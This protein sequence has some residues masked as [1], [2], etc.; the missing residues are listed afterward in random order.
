MV[1]VRQNLTG[2][3][4]MY[5]KVNN[6]FYGDASG[7][8]TDFVPGPEV[9]D[10]DPAIPGMTW[11]ATW[12][13]NANGV[14][15]GTVN[16]VARCTSVTTSN[17]SS[18]A[19]PTRYSQ[20]T[21]AQQTQFN[22]PFTASTVS[23]YNVCWCKITDINTGGESA[24]SSTANWT[25]YGIPGNNTVFDCTSGCTQRC[26]SSTGEFATRAG[27]IKAMFGQ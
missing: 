15:A 2:K 6:Q 19:N 20:L 1:P 9:L 25:H 5:D 17:T 16:G 26:S 24:S 10:Q 21:S 7:G 14:A 4:G 8:S 13:A 11:T 12:T 23:N 22:T 18:T 3:Y 27:F